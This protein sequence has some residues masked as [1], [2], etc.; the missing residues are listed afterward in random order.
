[1]TDPNPTLDQIE[2]QIASNRVAYLH[3]TWAGRQG[4]ADHYETLIDQLL[5]QWDN[6]RRTQPK[7]AT[8]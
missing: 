3:A 6:L 8:T 2:Q 7:P 5:G 4:D 1:M